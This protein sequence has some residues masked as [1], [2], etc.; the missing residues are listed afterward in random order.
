M[1]WNNMQTWQYFAIAGGVVLVLG[2]ILYFLPIGK[3]KMPAVV[4]AGFGGTALGLGLGVVLMGSLGYQTNPGAPPP[5]GAD[6][7]GPG[8]APKAL[9]KGGPQGKGGFGGGGGGFGQ[10]NSK[11]LLSSL[12]IALDRVADRP[13]TI[14]LTPE[15]RQ[16]IAEQLKGLDSADQLSEEEAKAR[17]DAIHKIVEKDKD[18]LEAVGYR[19]FAPPGKGGGGGG[20][21]GKDQPPNPFKEGT[22]AGRLKSLNDRLAGKK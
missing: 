17:L 14:A 3:A 13:V 12:V 5:A 19:G 7:A 10:P 20:G 11:A 1:D 6:G 9:G 22:A 15:Q 18:A 8:A 4:T 21:F 2:F 16:A